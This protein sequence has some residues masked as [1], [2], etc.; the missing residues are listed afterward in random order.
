MKKALEKYVIPA[1]YIV[2]I[3]LLDQWVK[4]LTLLYVKD[5]NGF[6]I[7]NKVLKIF[8]VKNE[9][10]AWGMLQNKQVLFII[11]TP[12]V[13][14]ALMYFYYKLPFEKKFIIARICLLCLCG[15]AIGNLIDRI[16]NGEKL[17]HGY[18]VDMIYVEIINFPVFNIAD[19]FITVGFAL[20]IFSM[21]FVYK[22]NDFDLLF[23]KKKADEKIEEKS[24]EPAE[25]TQE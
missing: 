4:L 5:T 6:Y 20:M 8:F 10:M 12:I 17:F 18:V 19:S 23:G 9:G 3:V 14:V 2:D 22:E 7:I 25:E 15:G 1:L 21:F 11:L 13:L 24:E 16:F